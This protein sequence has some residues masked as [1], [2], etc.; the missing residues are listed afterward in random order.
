M[1]EPDNKIV[2]KTGDAFIP[3]EEKIR[4]L[5][6]QE[7]ADGENLAAESRKMV[8]YLLL[9][10]K[11]YAAGDIRKAAAFEVQLGDE[12]A[13]SSVDFIVSIDGR[14]G[15]II[16]CAAGSLDSRQRQA[17][18]AAR[19]ISSPPAPVAVVADPVDANVLDV[20]TGKMTGEGFG[21]IPV[22]DQLRTIMAE[23]AMTSPDPKRLEKE[24]RILLAF[25]VIKC[26]V[27]QGK[28]GGVQIG[29]PEKK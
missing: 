24:K 8:E 28:D 17:V 10:K 29:E 9:E 15:M 7:I 22:K 26:C 1:K 13:W 25:D 19:V 18:A 14:I 21:A 20:A 6:A 5:L 11:G 4:Q 12:T 23:Q 2:F 16:K 27:P 3:R